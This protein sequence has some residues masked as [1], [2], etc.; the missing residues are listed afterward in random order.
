MNNSDDAH[1]KGYIN[2][3][4]EYLLS[5][6]ASTRCMRTT[7][8]PATPP[9]GHENTNDA[10]A[11]PHVSKDA[12]ALFKAMH[13]TDPITMARLLATTGKTRRHLWELVRH[14]CVQVDVRAHPNASW[15]PIMDVFQGIRARIKHNA[16]YQVRISMDTLLDNVDN[17]DHDEEDDGHDV[18]TLTNLHYNST[19]GDV[20]A[21]IEEHPWVQARYLHTNDDDT[22]KFILLH[23]GVP[24]GAT[25]TINDAIFDECSLCTIL[26]SD[27]PIALLWTDGAI[28]DIPNHDNRSA[29]QN[30]CAVRTQAIQRVA[31]AELRAEQDTAYVTS[32]MH[33]RQ[34]TLAIC[35]AHAAKIAHHAALDS[36]QAIDNADS[37]IRMVVPV[38]D[39]RHAFLRRFE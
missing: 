12:L 22:W 32:Q 21:R 27:I 19:W 20:M 4:K 30:R 10:D 29:W 16:F 36:E 39:L 13:P 2:R 14:G 6:A 9:G 35:I 24:Y 33:D 28:D 37:A 5:T 38:R 25:P 23:D 3:L 7:S 1:A 15:H 34:R 17:D 18:I 31:D 11:R 26:S 8:H